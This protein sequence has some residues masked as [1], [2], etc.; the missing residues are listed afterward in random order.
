MPDHHVQFFTATILKWIPLL[1]NDKY[2]QI[3]VDS[4][5]Y[6]T[7]KERCDIYSFVIMP[8]HIHVIWKINSKLKRE[9]I[10]RDFLSVCW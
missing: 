8:Y 9:A 2:K 5:A 4:M 6:L 1:N 10:Q 7:E 3:I